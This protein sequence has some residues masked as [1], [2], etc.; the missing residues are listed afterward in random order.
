MHLAELDGTVGAVTV[1]IATNWDQIQASVL[2]PATAQIFFRHFRH[3]VGLTEWDAEDVADTSA[4]SKAV[5]QAFEHRVQHGEV[6]Y[7]W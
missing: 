3:Q 6:L 2:R 7:L 5:E 4:T 1:T